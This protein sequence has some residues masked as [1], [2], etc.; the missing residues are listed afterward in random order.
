MGWMWN[1]KWLKEIV[2]GGIAIFILS[3]IISYI[4]TP[5]LDS[6]VL[7][8]STVRLVDGSSYALRKGKPLLIHFW[9]TWCPTCKLEA[10]NIERV[11][12]KY[13]VLTIA[14]NSGSDEKIRHFLQEKGLHYRVLNDKNGEWA[15]R[16]RVEAFPTTFIYNTQGIL[17]F[18]ETGYTTT[19]GLLA[20]MA[21]AE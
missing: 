11:S 3:N 13:E 1:K 4:R 2:I 6:K 19:A 8:A 18:T 15:K 14:V 21:L 9:A 5:E 20:R 12:Q 16:F 10:A 17:K 7:P